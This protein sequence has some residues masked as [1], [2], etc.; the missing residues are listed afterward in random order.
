MVNIELENRYYKPSNKFLSNVSQMTSIEKRVG[1]QLLKFDSCKEIQAALNENSINV[2]LCEISNIINTFLE[3]GYIT[4]NQ[5]PQLQK[6]TFNLTNKCSFQCKYCMDESNKE[7]SDELKY[8]ELIS[9]IDQGIKIGLKSVYITGGEPT[10]KE[11]FFD[12]VRYI[13]DKG[14]RLKINTD[15]RTL[16]NK[17]IK[18]FSKLK[19]DELELSLDSQ[20]IEINDYLRGNG[21]FEAVHKVIQWCKEENLCFSIMAT[22]TKLNYKE[23]K[24]LYTYVKEIGG[25][26]LT[27]SEI[28]IRGRAKDNKNDLE[29]TI[30][31]IIRLNLYMNLRGKVAGEIKDNDGFTIDQSE[32][33]TCNIGNYALVISSDGEVLPCGTFNKR[34]GSCGNVRSNLLKDIWFGS[35]LLKEI[36]K[37]SVHFIDKCNIC[38][39]RNLCG[40]GCRAISYNVSKDINSAADMKSC[41]I[42]SGMYSCFGELYEEYGA[43]N[44]VEWFNSISEEEEKRFLTLME[45]RLTQKYLSWRNGYEK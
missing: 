14:L 39:L 16:C 45:G 42:K 43:G 5:I 10:L 26:K 22:I 17:D 3:N 28:Y 4:E 29:L 40:G 25:N 23:Y 9:L 2:E 13:K 32:V 35:P 19:V 37:S 7:A 31:E 18:L 6:L 30:E 34:L 8:I 20:Y 44:F 1:M 27:L 38:S 41:I 15:G 21:S 11:G 36:R 12:F 24:S 33:Y